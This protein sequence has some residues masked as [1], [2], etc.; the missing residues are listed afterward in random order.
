[1]VT[2][3]VG[4]HHADDESDAPN[5]YDNSEVDEFTTTSESRPV[6][7]FKGGITIGKRF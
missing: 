2:Q 1:M 4:Y 3:S 5:Y 6:A 7:T